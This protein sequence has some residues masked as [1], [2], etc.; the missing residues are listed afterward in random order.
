MASNRGQSRIQQLL[1]AEQ[2][3]QRTVNAAKNGIVETLVSLYLFC[4]DIFI[5][6]YRSEL[7]VL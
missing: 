3:A 5:F 4:F 1:A 7:L 2:E 6:I